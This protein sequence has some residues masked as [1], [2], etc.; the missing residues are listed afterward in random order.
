MAC[1]KA[2]GNEIDH[3]DEDHRPQR[4]ACGAR[5]Q[6]EQADGDVEQRRED[7]VEARHRD[8]ADE[9]FHE[10]GCTLHVHKRDDAAC[11]PEN[12]QRCEDREFQQPQARRPQVLSACGVCLQNLRQ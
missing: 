1:E 6:G 2:S 4:E 8:V 10:I 12:R 7:C 5:V 9:A 3:T 11:D